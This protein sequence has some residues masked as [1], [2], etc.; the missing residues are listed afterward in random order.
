[1]ILK[2]IVPL[3]LLLKKGK[4][5]LQFEHPDNV[6]DDVILKGKK[7][8]DYSKLDRDGFAMPGGRMLGDD[9]VI[10]MTMDVDPEVDETGKPLHPARMHKV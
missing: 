3:T 8:G 4:N 2:L 6:A 5:N 1:M 7:R 9:V 10:G